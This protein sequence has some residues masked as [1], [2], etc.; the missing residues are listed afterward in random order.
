MT[1]SFAQLARTT[2]IRNQSVMVKKKIWKDSILE[3][4][5]LGSDKLRTSAKRIMR[6]NEEVRDIARDMLRSMYAAKGIGLAAPQ[7]GINKQLIVI[8]IDLENSTTPPI[9]LINPEI[10]ASN[11][12]LNTYEEG[13][14]SIPGV[15]LDVVRPSIIEVSFRDEQDF[16]R[17]LKTDGLLARCIQHEMDHLKGVLFVD[18]VKDESRLEEELVKNN[19]RKV[20]VK[21]II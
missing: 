8:D 16:P 7:V 21:K 3:I 5:K 10:I 19:L 15:Y 4:H 13:C 6:I 18:R 20:D 17:C 2:E 12:S 9:I 11:A 14:L 1:S